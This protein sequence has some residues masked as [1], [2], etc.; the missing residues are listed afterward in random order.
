MA[1]QTALLL[2][3]SQG[4]LKEGANK[5][6]PD[7][8]GQDYQNPKA[9]QR[10]GDSVGSVSTETLKCQAYCQGTAVVT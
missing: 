8:E 3:L 9:K 5:Y 1:S 6:N 7:L 10:Q 4:Q 2:W